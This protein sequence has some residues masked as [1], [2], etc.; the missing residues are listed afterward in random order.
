LLVMMAPVAD[1]GLVWTSCVF[2]VCC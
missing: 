1:V 2:T